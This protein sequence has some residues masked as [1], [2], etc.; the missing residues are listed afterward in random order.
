MVVIIED[1]KIGMMNVKMMMVVIIEDLKIGM[2]NVKTVMVMNLSDLNLIL[3]GQYVFF[4]T[5]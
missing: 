2:M 1:L 3:V 5:L 4:Y